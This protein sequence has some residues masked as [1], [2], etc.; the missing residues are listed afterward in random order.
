MGPRRR[1]AALAVLGAVV[2]LV[3]YVWVYLVTPIVPHAGWA[4]WWGWWDQGKTLES[5]EAFARLDLDPA[6]HWYPPGYALVGA[7]FVA[8]GLHAHAYFVPD[9]ACLLLT[10]LGFLG[11]ARSCG[12]SRAAAMA[13]FLLSALWDHQVW[14]EWV[15]PW[16]TT[17]VAALLWAMLALAASWRRESA[18]RSRWGCWRARC[19]W[20]GRRR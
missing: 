1:D 11:F 20:S 8:L 19:P 4:G 15:I 10:Y 7:P 3:A 17:L 12:V 9:L 16:N 6:H 14:R 2:L 13:L 5:A 18:A